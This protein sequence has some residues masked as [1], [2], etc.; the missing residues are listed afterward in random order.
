MGSDTRQGRTDGHK[1]VS[2][3]APTWGATNLDFLS[4]SVIRV[5]IHAPTWGATTKGVKQGQTITFQSTLPHGERLGHVCAVHNIK[6]FQSTLPH[7][8]R[9]TY[10]CP[11]SSLPCFNP[12][13]HMG[14]DG[15][16]KSYWR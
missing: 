4:N 6:W 5:S 10:V 15:Q 7:G 12:R 13:S 11:P 3:H 16:N 2:I 14:S 8:E 1:R 9:H